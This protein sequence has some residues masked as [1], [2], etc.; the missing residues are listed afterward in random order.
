VSGRQAHQ[1]SVAVARA[2]VEALMHRLMATSEKQKEALNAV[3]SAVGDDPGVDSGR[4]AFEYIASLADRIDELAR[5]CDNAMMLL[6]SYG[7]GF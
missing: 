4:A 3:A 1:E 7:Q 6:D 5:I 2:E